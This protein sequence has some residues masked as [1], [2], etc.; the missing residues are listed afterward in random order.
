[1]KKGG[2]K[3]K[4]GSFEWEVCRRLSLWWSDGKSRD[5]FCRTDSSGG[6]ATMRQKSGDPLKI[7]QDADIT[8]A[9]PDGLPFIEKFFIECKSGYGSWDI[10]DLLD[11][12]QKEPILIKFW[13]KCALG[14]AGTQKAPMLIFRRN[15]RGI[16]VVMKYKDCHELFVKTFTSTFA[17][18]YCELV[19]SDF[20]LVILPFEMFEKMVPISKF[21][22]TPGCT[23][24][25]KGTNAKKVKGKKL[26][27]T[28]G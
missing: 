16:C 12:R 1:M 27:G 22:A 15:R 13:I 5:I 2:G 3:A 8:F 23:L 21:T 28:Q 9:D 10:L 25:V 19:C 20:H 4:G 24:E 18:R 26:S 14:A 11:S 6:R 7:H 17:K